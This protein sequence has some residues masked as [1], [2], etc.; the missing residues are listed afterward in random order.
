MAREG[1][2]SRLVKE[3]GN[4]EN[5]KKEEE[6]DEVKKVQ[7]EEVEKKEK[8]AAPKKVAQKLMQGK[9]SNTSNESS[10]H[11]LKWLFSDLQ[12]KKKALEQSV[13]QSTKTISRQLVYT[14]VLWS[15]FPL[16]LCKELPSSM[17]IP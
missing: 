10:M 16:S 1:A 7:E 3:F 4:D 9:Q 5:E 13:G 6:V 14:W 15:F 17:L 8:E 12:R 2:F 11:R